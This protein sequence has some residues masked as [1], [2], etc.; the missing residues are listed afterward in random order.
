MWYPVKLPPFPSP[1]DG[2]GV[3]A[4]VGIDPPVKSS[5]PDDV[6]IAEDGLIGKWLLLSPCLL[7]LLLTDGCGCL[8]FLGGLVG[9]SLGRTGEEV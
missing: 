9:G 4:R 7:L 3:K 2:N 6:G 5:I 8:L 1:P